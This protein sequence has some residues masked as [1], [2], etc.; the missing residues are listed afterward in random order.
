MV[1]RVKGGGRVP[2]HPSPGWADF[3]IIMECKQENGH[4][5]AVFLSKEVFNGMAILIFMF[6]RCG[7][8]TPKNPGKN[9]KG[10]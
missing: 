7:T 2:P 3:T 1:D 6:L 4:C 5:H 10:Q 9:L 8:P